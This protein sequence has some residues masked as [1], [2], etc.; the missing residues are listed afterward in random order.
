MS[1]RFGTDGVRGVANTELT[2]EAVLALGRAAARVFNV[3]GHSNVWLIGRDTRRSG[4]LLQAALSIGLASEGAEVIDLGVIP[5][6]G[7]AYHSRINAAPA[8]MISASHNPFADNGIKLFSPGG[9]KLDDALEQEITT[10]FDRL[11]H[12]DPDHAMA[13]PRPSGKDIGVLRRAARAQDDYADYLVGLFGAELP[14][15]GLR[16]VVDCAN[17]AVSS[18]APQVLSSLGADVRVLAADPDGFNINEACG[19][20]HPESL[21]RAVVETKADLGL[22]FDGDADRLI[23]ID[24]TG[25]VVDGDR[26]VALCALDLLERGLLANATVV[27]TVM[28]NLGFVRAMHAKGVS[29]VQTN[30][31]DRYVLEELEANGYVLGG[32]QSGHVIFRNVATTGDGLLTGLMLIDL[33]VRAQRVN[34][35]M[36]FH[37]LAT[38]V[39]TTVPQLLRNVRVDRRDDLDDAQEIWSLVKEIQDEMGQSG[40]V[41]LRPSGTEPLIRV[42]V[43]ATDSA[44]AERAI[45]RLCAAL[46]QTLGG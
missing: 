29:V 3:H 4:T 34:P 10:E 38:E 18:I 20:T 25:S 44:T 31:G 42:M 12:T 33:F 7:V 26:V 39:M 46:T 5:T 41:L 11:L 23:A 19:S 40:R 21:S 15:A 32:E 45:D 43:E 1:L 8:A 14:F 16:V 36:T 6:P 24:H 9:L 37:A 30:V 22:A 27:V 35:T 13:E 28:S 17:G 2:P